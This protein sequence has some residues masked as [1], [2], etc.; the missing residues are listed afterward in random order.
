MSYEIVKTIDLVPPQ[1]EQ[2]PTNQVTIGQRSIK[3]GIDASKKAE[4]FDTAN[5]IEVKKNEKSYLALLLNKNGQAVISDLKANKKSI[6]NLI[7]VKRICDFYNVNLNGE[8]NKH[9]FDIEIEGNLI[10][11][12]HPKKFGE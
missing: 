9:T 10:V 5:L 11:L 8:F 2:K 12:Q 1:K 3:F 7:L 6:T 4:G